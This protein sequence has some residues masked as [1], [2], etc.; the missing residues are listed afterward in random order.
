M[1]YLC[2]FFYFQLWFGMKFG[3][4]HFIQIYFTVCFLFVAFVSLFWIWIWI[5]L[6]EFLSL[7]FYILYSSFIYFSVW[8]SFDLIYSCYF[9]LLLLSK[10]EKKQHNTSS[11]HLIKSMLKRFASFKLFAFTLIC[12]I[13]FN[14]QEKKVKNLNAMHTCV[15]VCVFHLLTAQV[16]NPWLHSTKCKRSTGACSGHASIRV[17]T[18]A[19]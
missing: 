18:R 17:C 11:F 8:F 4:V 7:L 14:V 15:C 19:K 10:I 16:I 1:L 9:F 3:L 6:V 13:G 2:A 5:Y 12:T